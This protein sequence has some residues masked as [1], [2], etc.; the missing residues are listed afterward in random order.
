LTLLSRDETVRGLVADF[1][2]G[3]GCDVHSEAGAAADGLHIQLGDPGDVLLELL[4]YVALSAT[5]A[6]IDLSEP[7]C[8]IT[9]RRRGAPAQVQLDLRIIDIKL[10]R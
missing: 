8:R 1:A 7:L 6:G 3:L 5:K 4:D 2:R 9:Y 10:L